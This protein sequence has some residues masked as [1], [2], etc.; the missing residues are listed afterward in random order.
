MFFL[1]QTTTILLIVAFTQAFSQDLN[2]KRLYSNDISD[3]D[4]LKSVVEKQL[5]GNRNL[6]YVESTVLEE[7]FLLVR[8]TDIPDEENDGAVAE[9]VKFLAP[10]AEAVFKKGKMI[11]IRWTGGN[12]EDE[13]ALDLFDGRFHY[14][15]IG[16]LKNSGTYPWI[17]PKDVEPGKQYK[18]KL[19]N[20]EDFGEYTFSESFIIKRK[21]PIGVWIIPGALV[22]G[23]AAYLLFRDN[24]SGELPDLP[25]PIEPN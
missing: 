24:S 14:R 15:H 19:T 7:P 20:T 21:V 8:T 1:K 16:E 23:G 6:T 5:E 3:S 13:F 11:E 10:V 9:P 4:Y 25:P 12:P 18:F 17:I 2:G 22:V